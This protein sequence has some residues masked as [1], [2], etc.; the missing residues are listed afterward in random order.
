MTND[1]KI[2][3]LKKKIADKKEKINA[4]FE[5]KTDMR[6]MLNGREYNI[7]SLQLKELIQAAIVFNSYVQSA[8]QLGLLEDFNFSEYNAQ[9][10]IEDILS[11]IAYLRNKKELTDLQVAERELESL[12][13]PEK[14][15]EVA[16][17]KI[18]SA[19]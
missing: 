8:K 7:N 3:E 19:I 10:Y 4:V 1:E 15:T 18:A 2:I 9:L 16:I 5:P 11:R 6:I 14:K 17:D 12:L 13:S